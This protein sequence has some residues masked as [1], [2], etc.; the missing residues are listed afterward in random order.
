[1]SKVQRILFITSSRIGD[2]VLSSGLLHYMVQTYP[3]AR[4]TIGCGPLAASLFEGVPNL[5]AV[6]PIRKQK[7]NKH[8]L[9]FWKKVAGHRWDIV[10]DLRDSAVSRLIRARRR[11]IF[12]KHIAKDQH[13]VSQN[14]AVM[15]L[16]NAPGPKLWFTEQQL[17]K[18]RALIPEGAPVLGVGPSA[19]WIGKTWPAD[20]FV[21]IIKFLTGPGGKMEAARVAV[22]A[23]PG[24]EDA[25][26]QVLAS[27]PQDRQLDIIAKTDPGVAAA[28]LSRCDFYIGNDSGLMH[29]AAA[30]GVPTLG[31][32]G[33][34]YP[35]IYAPWG[36]KAH[37]IST[38]ESFDDLRG[39]E[40][41]SP[42]TCG[43]LMGSLSVDA[44][45]KKLIDI[46]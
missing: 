43:C 25:A 27:I 30:C 32:F 18:A 5:E 39:Y 7:Y 29:C 6:I 20:R 40:G 2:A 16:A 23:A 26:R 22:F 35:H 11:Y 17:S 12:G 4:I 38:P 9:E 28:T 46:L 24:E 45:K 41:Y 36:R 14:A 33:P 19:N 21:E 10:V 31:L 42:Q 3:E 13:K 44:V 15:G 34:S 1:M 37:Y 8:W